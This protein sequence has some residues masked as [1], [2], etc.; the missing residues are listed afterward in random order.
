MATILL[1]GCGRLGIQLGQ[2][3]RTSGHRVI[4]LRRS[5]TAMPFERLQL[6]LNQP[7]AAT[8][9]PAEVDYVVYSATPDQRTREAYET[10]YVLGLKHLLVALSQQ[11]LKHF[12][13]VSSTAVYGQN[14]GSWVDEESETSPNKFNG[15][16][17]VEAEQ[18]LS[19]AA[20]PTS[21]VRFGGIYGAGRGRL[22]AK[23]QQGAEAQLEPPSY[24][25]RIHQDDCVGVLAFLLAQKE[26]GD[27]VLESC[28]LGVDSDPAAESDLYQWLAQTLNAPQPKLY[29][30][31][32][33]N[34]N[35]RCSNQRLLEAG[36]RFKYPSFREGYTAIIKEAKR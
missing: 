27:S 18:L 10:A 25:N 15:Q 7:I 24:T 4:G 19:S 28:Y 21:V 5:A 31:S 1:A 23:V 29:N 20:V 16:V 22:L 8:E 33:G 34:S 36:Y 6:D 9:L 12:F 26:S 14:D 35:K 17:I 13:F 3:L 11:T 30:D 2:Q 32:E